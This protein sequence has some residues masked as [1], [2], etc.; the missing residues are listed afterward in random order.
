[1]SNYFF[2][3]IGSIK[4]SK[5]GKNDQKVIRIGAGEA[6]PVRSHHLHRGGCL[7]N[8]IQET[9][10]LIAYRLSKIHI[11]PRASL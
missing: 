1:M 3:R 10:V 11:R 8:A 5:H 4:A 6:L 9:F 2:S 7:T